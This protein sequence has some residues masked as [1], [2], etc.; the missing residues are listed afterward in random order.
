MQDSNIAEEFLDAIPRAMSVIRSKMREVPRANLTL[1][2]FRLLANLAEKTL[3]QTELAEN[4]G[5]STPTLSRLLEGLKKQDLVTQIQDKKDRRKNH[6]TLTKNGLSKIT[7]IRENACQNLNFHFSQIAPSQKQALEKG[8][9]ALREIFPVLALIYFTLSFSGP[10]AWAAPSGAPAEAP[11]TLTQAI[12]RALGSLPS[13]KLA[14][15]KLAQTEVLAGAPYSQ[16]LPTLA[17]QGSSL[18]KKDASNVGTPRFDGEAYNQY[19]IGL[20]AAQPLYYSGMFAA[21]SQARDDRDLASLDVT[22]TER[23]IKSSVITAF[24][25]LILQKRKLDTLNQSNVI[26]KETLATAEKRY[27]IGRGQLLDVLQAKTQLSLL[28]GNIDS[29]RTQLQIAVSELASLIN[30]TRAETLDVTSHFSIPALPALL[31]QL[32]STSTRLPELEKLTVSA[33]KVDEQRNVAMGKHLP[34]LLATADWGR[35]AYTKS[36]LFD[37]TATTWTLGVQLS[38][39][40]FSGLSSVYERRNFDSQTAQI[41]AQRADLETTLSLSQIRARKSLDLAWEQIGTAKTSFELAK[42]TLDEAKRNYKLAMTDFLQLLS[43]EQ[44][45]LQAQ[46]ALDQAQFNYIDAIKQY[47]VATG[48][49]LDHLVP[50]LQGAPS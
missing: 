25:N 19:A 29:A 42:K 43:V 14:Q 24:F 13:L 3:T 20:H 45:Y 28:S 27:Q 47:G 48:I 16:L 9:R 49:S 46:S 23:A 37:G 22:L 18:Y 50:I 6:L 4:I 17:A 12:T 8:L 39:P 32:E 31:K 38:I 30:E 40:L 1:L 15:E 35:S 5:V 44:S 7:M 33:L 11:L 10:T 36:E 26:Q 21:I 34:Q 2:Q 41:A